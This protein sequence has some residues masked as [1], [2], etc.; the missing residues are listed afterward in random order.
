MTPTILVL[1]DDESLREMIVE[2]LE[3]HEYIAVG[4]AECDE[5]LAQ[6]ARMPFD[7]AISD[8]RMA[9]RLDGLGTMEVLKQRNPKMGCIIITGYASDS[10]VTRAAR[11]QADD[12]LYKP[13]ELL[14][15]LQMVDRVL[16][17][18]REKTGYLQMLRK[19]LAVPQKKVDEQRRDALIDQLEIVREEVLQAYYLKIRG[20]D[21]ML[22]KSAARDLWDR[23]EELDLQY[24]LTANWLREFS[25]A[26][27]QAMVN[28]YQQIQQTLL[29]VTQTQTLGSL[30][31]RGQE[32]VDR[33]TF[34][35]FFARIESGEVSCEQLKVAAPIRRLQTSRP[36]A[37]VNEVYQKI[38][39]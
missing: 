22:T 30:K 6:A 18:T 28:E 35:R 38:W 12:Y 26:I 37:E 32:Q 36:S 25:P 27:L 1:E 24:Q 20:R 4:A 39:A 2:I 15:L 17:K 13:V 31:A 29:E 9:G 5:A 14:S 34:Y 19:V 10:A 3:E 16:N 11:I 8:V 7:L 23:L 21:P 33:A